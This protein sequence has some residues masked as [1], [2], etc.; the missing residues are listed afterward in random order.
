MMGYYTIK[1]IRRRCYINPANITI[2]AIFLNVALYQ[3]ML[4]T[5]SFKPPV[6]MISLLT[7][8][9]KPRLDLVLQIRIVMYEPCHALR[10]VCGQGIHGVNDDGF[11]AWFPPVSPAVI[12][13]GI[14]KTLR[15]SRSGAR[16]DD[17]GDRMFPGKPLKR[18]LLVQV[19][20]KT[21]GNARKE[22]RI[23]ERGSVGK[24]DRDVRSL[25]N[26]ASLPQKPVYHPVK[27]R[28]GDREG[29]LEEILNALLNLT[30]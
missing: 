21:K 4:I 6:G 19:G 1:E 24:L 11:N 9:V 27:E 2:L 18:L 5:V 16:G 7:T 23:D 3:A 12:Q 30:G 22:I 14:E 20:R 13:D 29:C 15:L 28:C 25:E 10:L 26:P 8:D 17:R